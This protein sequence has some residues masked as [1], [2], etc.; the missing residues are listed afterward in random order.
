[1]VW[2]EVLTTGYAFEEL[3]DAPRFRKAFTRFAGGQRGTW[4]QPADIVAL[5][6]APEEHKALSGTPSDP[7]RIQSHIDDLAQYLGVPSRAH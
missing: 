7:E 5:L 4:P 3:R 2:L 1:M 6:P